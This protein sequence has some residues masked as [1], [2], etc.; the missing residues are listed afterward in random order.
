MK[1]HVRHLWIALIVAGLLLLVATIA[2]GIRA[3]AAS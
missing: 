1:W 2:I 3:G